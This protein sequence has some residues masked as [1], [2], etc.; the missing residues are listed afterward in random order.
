MGENGISML[1]KALPDIKK[2]YSA[3]V[4]IVNGEN[5][6]WGGTGITAKEAG[7]IFS[8]GASVIT[9]GNHSL[10]KA[11]MDFY[12]EN[13]FILCPANFLTATKERGVVTVDLGKSRLTVINLIGTA[14]LEAHRS[15]FTVL[16]EILKE[17]DCKNIFVDFHAESTREKYAFARYADG[18]VSR[19]AGTHTHVQ[20]N[21]EQIL[22][23]GTGYIT[24][25]GAVCALD[26]VL[27]VERE[28]AVEKQR[29][30][31]PSRFKVACG[32]G[33]VNGVFFAIDNDGRCTKTEKIHRWVEI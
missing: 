12:T 21:D 3:D 6:H 4:V 26:S 18:K 25:A 2:E 28:R 8:R 20:T 7:Y 17:T 22:P 11:D 9:G 15:P 30:L 1:M 32:N 14:F 13:E 29:F 10:R 16:D 31:T 19:V 33:Y 5:S 24:D 27:G 23:F